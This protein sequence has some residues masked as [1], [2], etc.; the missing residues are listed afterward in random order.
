[1]VT[2]RGRHAHADQPAPLP[3]T[4]RRG[5]SFRPAEVIG[6]LAQAFHQ[7]A[8][9]K[10][11]LWLFGIDLGVIEDAEF[12]RIDAELL[13]HFVH[14]D[15]KRH[16]AGRLSR[17]AHGVALGQIEHRQAHCGHPV[18]TGIQQARLADRGFRV[19]MGQIARPAF[20]TD[21]GKLAIAACGQPNPLDRRRA[22]RGIVEYEGARERHLDRTRDR[23]RA[24]RR[25][26][27]IGAHEQ[28]PAE[29]TADVR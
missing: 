20:M 23:L 9:R 22:M 3:A 7:L 18:G 26:D 13:G 21:R 4:G 29:T 28:F 25:Q 12:D 15:F 14:R 2:D 10:G 17:R 6:T 19:A 5:R 11:P 8:L 24:Q 1:M 16:Q 27:R